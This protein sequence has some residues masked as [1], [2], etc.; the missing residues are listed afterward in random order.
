VV[1]S[2]TGCLVA[3]AGWDGLPEVREFKR[4][5][6]CGVQGV[7]E[8]HTIGVGNTDY[9][10]AKGIVLDGKAHDVYK[11]WNSQGTVLFITI[12]KS[13][14]GLLL[15]DDQVRGDATGTIAEL[16]SLGVKPVLL[17]GDKQLAADRVASQAGIEVVRA[18]LLPDDKAKLLMQASWQSSSFADKGDLEMGLLKDYKLG[19]NEVGFIGDGLNDCPALASANIGIVI[20]QVGSQATVDASS[21]VLQGELGQLPAAIVIARRSQKLVIAN[22]CLALSINL[23]VIIAAATVGISLWVSVLLDNGTLLA[24][25]LNS[26]WPLCWRVPPVHDDLKEELEENGGVIAYRARGDSALSDLELES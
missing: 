9:L 8:G 16:K 3:F 5:G 2:Y 26:L 14:G 22:I 25:L 15:L 6:R 10:V 12:D 23:G 11:Q 18:G 7:I 24:V 4:E 17:T 1:E 13:I 21:A 19:P 20:Q